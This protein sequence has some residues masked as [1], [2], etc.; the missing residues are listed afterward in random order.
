MLRFSGADA[1]GL[2][3]TG[4]VG[5]IET[6]GRGRAERSDEPAIDALRT[7]LREIQA[8]SAV[9]QPNV[10]RPM[11]FAAA[12]SLVLA[13]IASVL[14]WWLFNPADEDQSIKGAL[15]SNQEIMVEASPSVVSSSA[16]EWT[17]SQSSLE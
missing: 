14:A 8:M 5:A 3:S 2:Y 16:A 15:K 12:A 6:I 13:A 7:R 9:D 11:H 1:I 10:R 17:S 4:A